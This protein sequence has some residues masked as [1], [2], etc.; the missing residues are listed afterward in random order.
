LFYNFISLLDDDLP[1]LSHN[2][3][4]TST[5]MFDDS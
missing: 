2:M 3:Y 4:Y 1:F 5:A